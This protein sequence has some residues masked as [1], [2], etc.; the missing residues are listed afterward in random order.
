MFER[1]VPL[2]PPSPPDPAAPLGPPD[3]FDVELSTGRLEL[4]LEAGERLGL[5]FAARQNPKRGFLFVSPLIGR[6][7]PARPADVRRACQ[8]LA[9]RLPADLPGPVLCLAVAEA[10]VALGEGIFRAYRG[11]T[12]RADV[13]FWHS[14]RLRLDLAPVARFTEP[15][16]H[17]PAHSLYAEAGFA[18]RLAEV[19]TLIIVDDEVTTGRT[20][21]ALAAALAPLTPRRRVT[22]ILALSDWSGDQP[23]ASKLEIEALL[24]GRYRFQPSAQGLRLALPDV[25]GGAQI[26]AH[27]ALPNEGRLGLLQP[28]PPEILPHPIIPGAPVLVVGIGEQPCRAIR[29]AEAVDAAGGEGWFQS[30][31]RAPVRLEGPVQSVIQGQDC[32]GE[33]L[34]DHVYNF[35]R[36]RWSQVWICRDTPRDQG[37]PQLAD[38]LGG[39]WV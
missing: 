38:A 14:S 6:Y 34:A 24:R 30:S 10:G 13:W 1:P 22:Q 11:Q 29:L 18:A 5:S 32:Y 17:A 2:T 3:A 39:R 27:G 19:G 12:G 36:G 26:V 37:C 9:A 28:Q 7:L 4:R 21:R 31:T 8:R 25:S 33:G 23:G 16:S 35:E 20:V 15:H